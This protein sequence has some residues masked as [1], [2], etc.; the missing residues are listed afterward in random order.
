MD[1]TGSLVDTKLKIFPS[2]ILK[3]FLKNVNGDDIPTNISRFTKN[4]NRTVT[5]TDIETEISDQIQLN[6]KDFENLNKIKIF[7]AKFEIDIADAPNNI[8]NTKFDNKDEEK[9]SKPILEETSENETEEGVLQS[10][11]GPYLLT[12]DLDWLF[13]HLQK[14][15]TNGEEDI[16]Y[17]HVLLEGSH[18]ETPQNKILKRNPD[19][20]A[21]CV[22]L[23]AQQEAREYR[24]MTKSVD[25]VR[26]RFPEDSISYQCK[27]LYNNIC[28]YNN[29]SIHILQNII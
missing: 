24:Q 27:Y 20:E 10:R 29:V 9:N 17:L 22:K 1:L 21:R 16:P 3:Q 4:K 2:D 15:R 8:S 5:K 18:I 11:D 7:V 13:S 14:R 12:S 26:M 23:R 19:L 25:N 28:L 6:N